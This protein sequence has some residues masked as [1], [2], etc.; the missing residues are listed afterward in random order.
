MQRIIT[1]R[2][3]PALLSIAFAGAASASGFQLYGR[4]ERQ[5][6]RQ[7]RRRF[8]RRRRKRQHRLLQPGRHD[9]VAAAREVSGGL[10]TVNTSFEFHQ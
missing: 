2:L 6:H 4:A 8:R 3:I 7:C 5:R 9:P 10:S 1:P